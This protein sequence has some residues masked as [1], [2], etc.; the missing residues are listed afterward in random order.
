VGRDGAAWI[1][2]LAEA[3]WPQA[4]EVLDF[5]H[6]SQHLWELGKALEGENEEKIR[7]WVEP[8]R[9][10][11]RMGGEKKVLREIGALKPKGGNLRDG[12]AEGAGILLRT[13]ASDELSDHPSQRVADRIWGS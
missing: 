6:A 1:W 2:N 3:R 8:R 12:G 11:M 4:E 13:R 9:H 5:Y 10:R 7:A